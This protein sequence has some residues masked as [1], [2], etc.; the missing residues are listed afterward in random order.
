MTN[1]NVALARRWFEE[2]W[3]QRRIETVNELLTPDSVCESETGV[4][5]GPEEFLAKAYTPFIS[6]LPDL[7][8]SIDDLIAEGDQVAVRW[9]ATGTHT[10]HVND[11][12]ATGR[13]IA[14]RGITWIRF[15]AGKMMEGWDSWNQSGVIQA[16][17]QGQLSAS[18]AC[19]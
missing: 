4:L 3:N 6:M 18:V 13:R 11:L 19:T 17:S 16:L 14:F 10:S 1:P 7:A 12:P 9:R 2:V 5:K 15:R 8:I